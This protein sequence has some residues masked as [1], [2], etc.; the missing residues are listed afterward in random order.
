MKT[1]GQ[2]IF[3]GKFDP[4]LGH[5]HNDDY[6][7]HTTA[8]ANLPSIK[9]NGLRGGNSSTFSGYEANK[10]KV[11]L[12]HNLDG[13]QYWHGMVNHQVTGDVN[14]SGGDTTILRTKKAGIPVE[15]SYRHDEVLAD[16]VPP[17]RLEFHNGKA[18]KKL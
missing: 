2:Y 11:H 15:K 12:S 18:W 13:A 17:D 14:H 7:H 4:Q 10:E 3:E 16:H 9:K 5:L 1:F 6:Y 8:S